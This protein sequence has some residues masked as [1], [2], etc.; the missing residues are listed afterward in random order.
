M[1][2][3]A[4]DKV[5]SEAVRREEVYL[6][7]RKTV[8]SYGGPEE[9]GWWIRDSYVEAFQRFATV[10]SAEAAKVRVTELARELSRE[11]SDRF[12]RGCLESLDA[13]E[14]RGLYA[15]DL[16]EVDGPDEYHVHIEV[17]YPLDHITGDRHYS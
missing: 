1:I 9:G 6:V 17:D 16:P 10:E 13:A 12:N 7:L 8:V 14:A 3:E 4:F 15:E 11:A 5:C 2:R